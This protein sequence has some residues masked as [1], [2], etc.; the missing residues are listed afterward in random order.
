M[1]T[2]QPVKCLKQKHNVLSSGPQC[3]GNTGTVHTGESTTRD[4][5]GADGKSPPS[6]CPD[7][8]DRSVS[9]RFKERP[10]KIVEVYVC[11]YSIHM[12][13][14]VYTNTKGPEEKLR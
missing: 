2:E 11:I 10:Q 1:K 3:T 8:L 14:S 12:Y 9:Y 4:Q 6:H 13:L 5:G 7:S